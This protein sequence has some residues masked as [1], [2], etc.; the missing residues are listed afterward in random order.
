MALSAGY[1]A[2]R[3][4]VATAGLTKDGAQWLKVAVDPY[5]DVP[6]HLQGLPDWNAQRTIV[7]EVKRT[8]NYS[9]YSLAT[10]EHFSNVRVDML[11]MNRPAWFTPAKHFLKVEPD[12]LNVV[13][14]APLTD[15]DSIVCFGWGDGE[16]VPMQQLYPLTI[17]PYTPGTD[18]FPADGFANIGVFGPSNT[19]VHVRGLTQ[20][21]EI[22]DEFL[23][24]G[25][26]R[27]LAAG[28]EVI[29]TT[30]E[31]NVQGSVTTYRVN[32]LF[33]H[34]EHM[35]SVTQVV[36]VEQPASPVPA[37]T[38][39][40]YGEYSNSAY[41]TTPPPNLQSAQLL[42]GTQQ[43]EARHGCYVTAALNANR[44][45]PFIDISQKECFIGANPLFSAD[46]T[47]KPILFPVTPGGDI[48]SNLTSVD[49]TNTITRWGAT[50]F[51]SVG[52]NAI[53]P[54]GAIFEGLIETGDT[55]NS[56]AHSTL[57]IN[58]KWIL[59]K[60]PTFNSE[61]ITLAS[62][63][64]LYDP[65]TLTLYQQIAQRLPTGCTVAM[66][67]AGE[68]WEAVCGILSR[69]AKPVG[70]AIGAAFGAPEVGYELGGMVGNIAKMGGMKRR[71]G[72]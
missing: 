5:H 45:Y 44:L 42:L 38:A 2:F 53:I 57:Q 68:W 34:A 20:G 47:N 39:H 29:N 43:W 3:D 14:P 33:D 54:C 46:N 51:P 23:F 22:G 7:L 62:I 70:T 66:N 26:V 58:A 8:M 28:F 4:A 60:I 15:V 32:D 27:V 67:P 10:G 40:L 16:T 17:T 13:N 52:Y 48:C 69:I 24:N 49:S 59:E 19:G 63:S 12:Q 21:L 61:L 55:D 50:T 6:Q 64:A 35:F 31:L 9:T 25:P 11:P 18:V 72:Y 56:G 1:S 30:N 65:A 37:Y 71:R 36:E 41:W